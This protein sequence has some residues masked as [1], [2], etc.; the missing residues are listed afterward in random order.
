MHFFIAVAITI[1]AAMGPTPQ[2]RVAITIDDLPFLSGKIYLT[3]KQEAEGFR[4][5]M[6]TLKKHGVTAFGFVNG[7]R[8]KPYHRE[9][10]DEFVAAGHTIGNHTSTHPDLN[11][12]V[13]DRYEKDIADG[14]TEITPWVGKTKY[15]RYPMLHEGPD[16]AKRSAI[17]DYLSKNNLVSVPVTIDNDDWLYNR[18]YCQAIKSRNRRQADSIGAAYLVHIRERTAYF[19]SVSMAKVGRSV[20]HILLIHMTLLNADYLDSLLSWYAN[21]GW[22][23]I[24][25]KDALADSLY[26]MPQKYLGP[27][28]LSVLLRI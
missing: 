19:D 9:L 20:D 15:F 4:K 7:S 22:Q 11:S 23:F 26:R 2:K 28:G 6:A 12:T 21:Q 1:L 14:Q 18:D 25:P 3:P 10:F 8:I 17:A 5:V 16:E 24:S 27:K 13:V